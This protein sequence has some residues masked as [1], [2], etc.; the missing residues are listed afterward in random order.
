MSTIASNQFTLRLFPNTGHQFFA[1]DLEELLSR[2]R[3]PQ[4]RNLPPPSQDQLKRFVDIQL[5]EK[6]ADSR[7]RDKVAGWIP[8]VKETPWIL[9]RYDFLTDPRYSADEGRGTGSVPLRPVLL[10][11]IESNLGDVDRGILLGLSAATPGLPPPEHPAYSELRRRS[12]PIPEPDPD[13]PRP[14][15]SRPSELRS[16]WPEGGLWLEEVFPNPQ[17]VPLPNRLTPQERKEFSDFVLPPETVRIEWAENEGDRPVDVDL[18]VDLGNSRTVCLVLEDHGADA[19]NMPFGK[20]VEPVHFLPRGWSYRHPAIQQSR[21]LEPYGIIDSWILVHRSTFANLEPPFS[22]S[23]LRTFMTA[24]SIAQPGVEM[25]AHL[26]D[27]RFTALAPVLVG[28]GKEATGAARTLA[29]AVATQGAEGGPFFLSSP[30]RYA[31]DDISIGSTKQF[32]KQVPNAH[33]VDYQTL[34]SLEGMIRMVMN[35]SSRDND[36][37]PREI[38]DAPFDP[39]TD[40]LAKA[41]Y[42]RGDAICWFALSILETTY[43]QINSVD[44]LRRTFPERCGVLRRLRRVRVTYPAGW[45]GQERER[46]L[47]QWRRATDLFSLAHLSRGDE[48]P[49][50]VDNPIDEAIASQLPIVVSEI[51]NL[52]NDADEWLTLYGDGY[53]ARMLSLDI[54]GGTTDIA[55][56]SYSRPQENA[57]SGELESNIL[58]RDGN[59]IAGDAMVKALIERLIIPSWLK[60]RGDILFA[61]N[62]KAR[63]LLESLFR[64]PH[65]QAFAGIEAKLSQILRLALIPLANDILAKVNEAE[66]S[67]LS[68]LPPVRVSRAADPGA[69]DDLNRLVLFHLIRARCPF[70]DLRAAELSRLTHEPEFRSWYEDM[71]T[72]NPHK[73]PFPLDAELV[74]PISKV[75]EVVDDVFTPVIR[76][77]AHVISEQNVNLVIVSGKPSEL[78]RMRSILTRELPLP[79]QRII[80]ARGHWVGDWYPVTLVEDG[81][82]RDAKT[83]TV[84]GAALFEDIINHNTTGFHLKPSEAG[85]TGTDET[86]WG[87]L[88]GTTGNFAEEYPTF[89]EGS[90]DLVLDFAR[91]PVGVVFGRRLTSSGRAEPVYR[92]DY[93][94]PMGIEPPKTAREA[95]VRAKVRRVDLPGS[96][97]DALELVPGSVSF[98]TDDPALDPS[99]IQLRLRTMIEESF[100]MDLPRFQVDF[101]HIGNS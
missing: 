26:I 37:P 86:T 25:A 96:I 56:V 101:G 29:R 53:E 81:R 69:I 27:Q 7:K 11:S 30:K 71:R 21:R 98:C 63:Q 41:K 51:K 44:F 17:F 10:I 65:Q 5:P 33:D 58:Y 28:G 47:D 8:W 66:R 16:D 36:L 64:A 72:K 68:D 46:Y 24:P 100:W 76:K 22:A 35:P 19:G 97:G 42:S 12:T 40:F 79:A 70:G 87:V 88:D 39:P 13:A 57:L 15:F 2:R 85:D 75:H 61:G 32:W 92:L 74:F 91:L 50:L 84:T 14:Y 34:S 77:L 62:T 20:R 4:G 3:D 94:A 45:T 89:T 55:V 80:Q 6:A 38:Y 43:R 31:W 1:L 49:R 78:L 90:K 18:I 52:G 48:R 59:N 9:Y 82:I 93:V 23:K 73:L 83:V 60:I 99:C 95:I 54:G 67:G